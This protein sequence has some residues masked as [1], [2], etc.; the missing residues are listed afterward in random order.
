MWVAL[1]EASYEAVNAKPKPNK[2]SMTKLLQVCN[3]VFVRNHNR[4][5][6]PTDKECNTKPGT[7]WE[8]P[9]CGIPGSDGQHRRHHG[10]RRQFLRYQSEMT[11]PTT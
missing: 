9:L 5:N 6:A 10:I 7:V 4:Q 1:L 11:E 2:P 8:V 3:T